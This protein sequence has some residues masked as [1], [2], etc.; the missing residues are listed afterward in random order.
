M[1]DLRITPIHI[2]I[3]TKIIQQGEQN[4]RKIQNHSQ[5]GDIDE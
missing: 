5:N 1:D 3:G 2:N 4:L